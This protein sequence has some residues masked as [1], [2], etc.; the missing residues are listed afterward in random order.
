[1]VDPFEYQKLLIEMFTNQ[2]ISHAAILFASLTASM[3]ALGIV[4]RAASEERGDRKPFWGLKLV[5]FIL[6]TFLLGTTAYTFSRLFFYGRLLQDASKTDPQNN[7]TSFSVYYTQVV[8]ST[9]SKVNKD[10]SQLLVHPTSFPYRLITHMIIGL[11]SSSLLLS[12][13]TNI[14]RNG[15]QPKTDIKEGLS[16]QKKEPTQ[17]QRNITH[18][19]NRQN[20][21]NNLPQ[22][23]PLFS[24]FSFLLN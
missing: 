12:A 3:T 20:D 22:P 11:V 13:F 7:L 15:C 24:S 14:I 2:L 17:T 18:H 5:A 4:Q 19:Y 6:L 16:V 23:T 9:T 10:C 21:R 1:M 8:G